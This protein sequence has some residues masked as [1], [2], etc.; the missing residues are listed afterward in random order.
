MNLSSAGINKK[1]LLFS[2]AGS[3]I[4]RLREAHYRKNCISRILFWT[5]QERPFVQVWEKKLI[6]YNEILLEIYHVPGDKEVENYL[7]LLKKSI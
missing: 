6:Q 7:I 2:L 5:S 1:V 4:A 3:A